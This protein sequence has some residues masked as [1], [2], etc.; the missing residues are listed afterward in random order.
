MYSQM[1]DDNKWEISVA[2]L[3][4]GIGSHL[5]LRFAQRVDAECGII[6]RKPGIVHFMAMHI[7]RA[8][9]L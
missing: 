3:D 8:A 9:R 2:Q 4:F 6:S 7:N 1:Y 5:H